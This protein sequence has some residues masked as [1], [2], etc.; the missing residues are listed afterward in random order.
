MS[1]CA[2]LILAGGESTRMGQPKAQLALPNKSTVLDFH[3]ACAKK[4]NLPIFLADN[5]K[6]SA[7]DPLIT[8]LK[9]YLPCN[10]SGKGAGPLSGIAAGLQAVES[11]GYILTVSCDHL[12]A[13]DKIADILKFTSAQ[14]GYLYAKKDCPLL[15]VYHTSILPILLDFLAQGSRSVMQFLDLVD[16]Q[17]FDLNDDLHSLTN[18]NTPSEFALALENFYD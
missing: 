4:L 1:L 9:D 18:F 16:R 7:H 3:I 12:L 13:I 14:V 5:G 10:D 8:P 15:G 6:N 11:E 2:V 17:T